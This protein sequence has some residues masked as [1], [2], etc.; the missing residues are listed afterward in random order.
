MISWEGPYA[1][2][3]PAAVKF[4][5]FA[6]KPVTAWF[7]VGMVSGTHVVEFTYAL[8]RSKSPIWNETSIGYVMSTCGAG[9]GS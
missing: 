9:R 2:L 1:V 3:T 4:T 8:S 6:C 5:S 7:S